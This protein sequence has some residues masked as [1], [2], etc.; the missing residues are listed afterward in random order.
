LD[1]GERPILADLSRRLPLPDI[2]DQVVADLL[3][4]ALSV[5]A[6]L[7]RSVVRADDVGAGSKR[8]RASVSLRGKGFDLVVEGEEALSG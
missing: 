3:R 1:S 4:D 2:D 7:Q 5:R 6:Y 8:H